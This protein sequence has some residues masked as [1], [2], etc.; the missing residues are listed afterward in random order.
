MHKEICGNPYKL[1]Q[2][3]FNLHNCKDSIFQEVNHAVL[4]IGYGQDETTGEK[5]WIVKNSWGTTWGEDGYF[6]IR[7]GTDE[8]AIES[9]V[10]HATPI[11]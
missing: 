11:P 7:R 6:R 9:C 3:H 5:Y 1:Y 10:V 4:L 8:V 2:F